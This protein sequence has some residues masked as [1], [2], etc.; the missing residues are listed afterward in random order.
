M[1]VSGGITDERTAT[2]EQQLVQMRTRFTG[3][4][5]GAAGSG[6]SEISN[7]APTGT[8]DS[9]DGVDGNAAFT[10]ART[11]VADVD[12]H[13]TLKVYSDGVRLLVADFTIAGTSLT[14]LAPNIPTSGLIVD[15][16]F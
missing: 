15:Y 7:E 12:G 9:T 5:T 11:P 6:V 3:P 16:R 13:T 4:I 14:I 1:S 8:I 10:L 2:G